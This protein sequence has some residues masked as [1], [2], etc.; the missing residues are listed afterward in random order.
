M[1]RKHQ[2]IILWTIASFVLAIAFVSFGFF[3]CAGF[4]QIT[5]TLTRASCNSEDSPFSED[6][7]VESALATRDYA[8]GSHN[9]D[10]L[11]ETIATINNEA[12]TP[13][14]NASSEELA[15]ADEVYTLDTEA[16]SHLDDVYEVVQRFRPVLIGCT[17]LAGFCLAYCLFSWGRRSIAWPLTCAGGGVLAV[18]ALLGLWALIDFSSLFSLFHSLFFEAGTWTFSS[19]SLLICQFPEA[20]WMGMAGIW[21]ALTSGLSILSLVCGLILIRKGKKLLAKLQAEQACE[22]KPIFSFA[23]N[24]T[25]EDGMS[26]TN[27]SVRVRFAPSPTGKLHVG[28][29]R[30]AL[31]NWAFARANGGSFI[32]RI[33]DTDPERSTPENVEIILGALKWLGLDWD[34]GP[35]VEGIAGPYFQ[36]QR[37]K[38]YKQALERLKEREAVYPC[39]CSKEELDA[40]R[41]KAEKEEGG[42]SGYDRS[43]RDIDPAEAQRRIEAGEAHTWRLKVPKDHP[44]ISFED[45]V[46]GQVSFPAEVMDDMI[47]VRTDGSPTYNFAVVCDDANMGITHVIRGDDHLSN[48]P[49][50]ILIYEALGYPIPTFAHL[51]MILGPDGKKLSKRHGAASVE[52]FRDKGYLP[53]AMVNFLALLGWSLDGET[54]IIDR[55]TLCREF[56]L[57]RITKKDAIFD[58]TKLQWMNA[59]YIKEMGAQAWVKAASSWLAEAVAL[60]GMVAS[61]DEAVVVEPS[62][63]PADPNVIVSD[64]PSPSKLALANAAALVE[65]EPEWFAQLYP[66]VAERL[67]RLDEIP[68]KLS[69]MFWGD[70]V[71]LDEK[72]VRK[73][74]LKEGARADEALAACRKVLSNEEIEWTHKSLEAACRKEGELLDMKVKNLL[75][76]LRVAICGN[77]VSPPLFESIELLPRFDVLARIDAT[78]DA[79]LKQ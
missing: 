39:F 3:V 66:L 49:R 68:Q 11:M 8:F 56:S 71:S 73:V 67:N 10:D 29:A 38:S 23:L 5:E 22:D 42:Y 26:Q 47:V 9:L 6:A 18:F 13:Y 32:L 36:T 72:S 15:A 65:E 27:S 60:G 77:M 50:Q 53:D 46:Y 48:T 79:I 17:V 20:F 45:A 43:C 51:S 69:Y 57:D 59:H 63:N 31:Y 74:L 30:T 14:A 58:E 37:T 54:S 21:L 76:P 25:S 28:G 16:I 4:P 40:K 52:E 64:T 19:D 12:N 70:R 34:E 35:E 55:E 2:Q 33:E 24:N 1:K 78:T 75:Q 7:L 41:Q 61:R 62:P 44:P